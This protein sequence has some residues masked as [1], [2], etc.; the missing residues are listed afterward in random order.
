[1]ADIKSGIYKAKVVKGSEEYGES[2]NKTPE[3][4]LRVHVPELQREL[5]VVLYFSE[6]ASP[7]SLE[8]LRL[9]GW[10]GTDLSD[11]TGVDE[12]EIEIEV[13]YEDYQGAPK[14][15]VGIRSGGGTFSTKTPVDK[16]AFAAK[17]A[18]IAGLPAPTGVPKPGF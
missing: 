1:M 9:C 2:A 15:K 11:L 4:L 17:V 8:R 5:T 3:L 18:A 6:S 12:N 13:K 10:K 14:M 7:Y 16:K